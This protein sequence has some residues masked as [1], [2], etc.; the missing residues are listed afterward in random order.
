M[1]AWDSWDLADQAAIDTCADALLTAGYSSD[2]HRGYDD[3]ENPVRSIQIHDPNNALHP[4]DAGLTQAVVLMGSTLLVLSA[5]D[6][7]ASPFSA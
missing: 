3:S 6:Y 5:D 1:P 4:V 2:V 7:A